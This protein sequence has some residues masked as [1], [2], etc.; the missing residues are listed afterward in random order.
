[1]RDSYTQLK[2]KETKTFLKL[3]I[4]QY[5]LD[6]LPAE[7]SEKLDYYFLLNQRDKIYII[8]KSFS[9]V[10]FDIMNVQHIGLYFCEWQNARHFDHAVN[11]NGLR[12]YRNN[13][14]RLSIE[15][16]QIMFELFNA[17]I[18]KNILELNKEQISLW[19]KGNDV[20]VDD[21]NFIKD[22]IVD[23]YVIVKNDGDVYG[24]GIIKNGIL[25]NFVSKNR[26]LRVV[27]E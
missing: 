10:D 16:S 12:A 14:V 20:A 18:Q 6:V 27:F 9:M 24:C 13:V 4:E 2:S 25:L 26:R 3:L 11:S 1:M 7:L 17:K 5:G 19:I 23:S 21:N 8:N 22:I 15:G